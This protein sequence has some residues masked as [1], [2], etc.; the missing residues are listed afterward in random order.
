MPQLQSAQPAPPPT[1]SGQGTPSEP[2]CNALDPFKVP[3]AG[4]SAW[5][6]VNVDLSVTTTPLQPEDT[7]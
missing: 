2:L 4:P 6:M 7:P 3:Q 1:R 5:C